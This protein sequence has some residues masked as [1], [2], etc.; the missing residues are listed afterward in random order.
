MATKPPTSKV[1]LTSL[2]HEN[3]STNRRNRNNTWNLKHN[4]KIWTLLNPCVSLW[5]ADHPLFQCEESAEQSKGWKPLPAARNCG[6]LYR[7]I[8][9]LWALD[10]R[11]LLGIYIYIWTMIWYSMSENAVYLL[12]VN[13]GWNIIELNGRPRHHVLEHCM[14]GITHCNMQQEQPQLRP[15]VL[16]NKWMAGA[17]PQTV[18][19]LVYINALWWYRCIRF[20]TWLGFSH[21]IIRNCVA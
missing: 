20:P 12:V 5:A 19:A 3:W 17:L 18:A 15:R 9:M 13:R 16:A 14:V 6:S 1:L 10:W 7:I 21:S 8:L 2:T 4:L 11:Y